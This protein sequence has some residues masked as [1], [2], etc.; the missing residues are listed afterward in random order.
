MKKIAWRKCMKVFIS[1]D[2]EGT[3]GI[4]NFEETKQNAYFNKRMTQEVAAVC[5]G[6]NEHSAESIIFVKDAHGLGDNID[7]ELLPQNVLLNRAFSGHPLCM[8]NLLDDSFDASMATGY[9]SPA[10]SD[11]NPLAHTMTSKYSRITLNGKI[12]SEFTIAYY[13][14]LYLGVPMVLVAGDALLMQMVKETDTDILTVETV[15]GYGSSVTSVHPAKS[16]SLLRQTA[17][18]ALEN[19]ENLKA[20]CAGKLPDMFNMEISF[21]KHFNAFLASYFPGVKSVDAH[22]ISFSSKDFMEILRLLLFV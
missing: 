13:T 21:R 4:S 6:I 20:K 16:R 11:G 12:C 2:I 18:E 3:N 19:V 10:Y 9:H 7:H 5:E 15:A 14:S 22:T 1:A 8:M 17:K